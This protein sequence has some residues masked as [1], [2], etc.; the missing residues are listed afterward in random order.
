MPPHPMATF[1]ST[2]FHGLQELPDDESCWGGVA[3]AGLFVGGDEGIAKSILH[4]KTV[5]SS[6]SF[7]ARWRSYPIVGLRHYQPEH[8]HPPEWVG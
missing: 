5:C 6:R 1:T 8:R 7:A 2:D 3:P 4:E